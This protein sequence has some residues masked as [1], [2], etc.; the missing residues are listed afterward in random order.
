MRRALVLLVA[1]AACGGS[2]EASPDDELEGARTEVRRF[3]EAVE[4]S[5]CAT[6]GAL[7]PAAKEQ[8]GCEKVLHE[9]REDLKITLVDL[10]DVRRDGRDKQAIIVRATVMRRG[11]QKTM[12]F[13][14]THEQGVWQL[15]L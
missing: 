4:K 6:L 3:F 15:V 9:W 12:L 1:L 7:L 10:P 11:E 8:A 2:R 14:V 5:D 13:R